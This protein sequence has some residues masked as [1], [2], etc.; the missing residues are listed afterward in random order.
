M[1]TCRSI[2]PRRP[3]EC[4]DVG[5]PAEALAE[6]RLLPFL[7]DD[8]RLKSARLE[9][10]RG[11]GRA[12]RGARASHM[13]AWRPAWYRM[14]PLS[15]TVMRHRIVRQ[16]IAR[17]LRRSLGIGARGDAG[18]RPDRSRSNEHGCRDQHRHE[19][20]SRGA[21]GAHHDHRTPAPSSSEARAE[22]SGVPPLRKR[23]VEQI[24]R[25]HHAG[26]RDDEPRDRAPCPVDQT[27][28][29][30]EEG[31]SESVSQEA[32]NRNCAGWQRRG[33]AKRSLALP[34][35]EQADDHRARSFKV[36]SERRWG[37]R[38]HKQRRRPPPASSP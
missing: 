13:R 21:P 20:S 7:D 17:R 33:T 22:E 11:S 5:V 1:R 6:Q 2:E 36:A 29:E 35:P 38:H 8:E 15:Q 14:L 24:R 34:Y 9:P 10:G 12:S 28:G 23:R 31:K 18:P 32:P 4:R 3:V 25:R 27:G 16:A 19:H 37:D 26:D 30:R